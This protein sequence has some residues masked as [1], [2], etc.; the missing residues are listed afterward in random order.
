MQLILTEWRGFVKVK[1]P[2]PVCRQAGTGRSFP[3][4]K[5]HF[6]LCPFIRLQGGAEYVPAKHGFFEIVVYGL[7]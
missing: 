3:A 5:F 7:V 1:L 4:R 6:A 2:A